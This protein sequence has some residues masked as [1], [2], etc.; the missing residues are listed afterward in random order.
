MT[1]VP[2]YK[3][4]IKPSWT[5]NYFAFDIEKVKYQKCTGGQSDGPGVKKFSQ[6]EIDLVLYAKNKGNLTVSIKL[7]D[8]L[9]KQ[10]VETIDAGLNYLEMQIKGWILILKIR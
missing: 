4:W 5:K 6:P 1:D 8:V 7:N 2:I 10:W 9:L 3:K